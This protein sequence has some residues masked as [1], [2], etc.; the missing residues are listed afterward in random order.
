MADHQLFEFD[1]ESEFV[2]SPT[3]TMADSAIYFEHAG[4][5]SGRGTPTLF[6]PALINEED[7]DEHDDNNNSNTPTSPDHSNRKAIPHHQQRIIV[8]GVEMARSPSIPIAGSSSRRNDHNNNSNN[9]LGQVTNSMVLE[10]HQFQ[11]HDAAQSFGRSV[12]GSGGVAAAVQEQPNEEVK[13]GLED[14][15]MLSV[16]GKGAFGKVYL[17]RLKGTSRVFALK[18]LK[19]AS[20]VLHSK[21][22]EHT[23][24]ERT[25]LEEVRHPFIVKLYYAFQTLEKLYLVLEYAPGGELFNQLAIERMLSEEATSFYIAELLLAIEHLHNLGIIYRDLK[26]E[27]CLLDKDGHILLTDFGLSKTSLEAKTVCGTVEFMPPEIILEQ[28]YDRTVDFW[29]LGIMTFNLLTGSAPFTGN[30]RK[31]VGEKIVKGKVV[32]PNY[33]SSFAK[34]FCIRL[35]RKSPT[36]RLGSGGIADI[37]KHS[38]FRKLDW[39]KLAERQVTPPIVPKIESTVDVRNFLDSFTSM[40][41]ESP[42]SAD[43]APSLG[44]GSVNVEDAFKG[45]SYVNKFLT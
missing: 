29:A 44:V 13:V 15:E 2:S 5:S 3:N 39:K 4:A 31:K 20:I 40:A 37:K 26:P 35:L 8:A 21:T 36:Q 12:G 19:K 7:D 34:D 10:V 16:I 30:N 1:D 42:P 23:R 32:C 11:S 43:G 25:I 27:N 18:V 24:N 22:H 33:M 28:A 45:F 9:I 6:P 38:F 17:V 41:L 14:F